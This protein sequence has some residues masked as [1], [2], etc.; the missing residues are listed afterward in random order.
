MAEGGRA[1]IPIKY[2]LDSAAE[3]EYI[4]KALPCIKNA[5]DY[6]YK[7][8]NLLAKTGKK[9]PVAKKI[10]NEAKRFQKD[11]PRCWCLCG[12]LVMSYYNM[13]EIRKYLYDDILSDLNLIYANVIK[14]GT[15]TKIKSYH[16]LLIR[17]SKNYSNTNINVIVSNR[18]NYDDIYEDF[19]EFNTFYDKWSEKKINYWIM[20]KTELK[21]CPYCNILYTYNRGKNVTAQLDHFFPKSEYPIFALCFY[22][23]IPSCPACNK[24]KRDDNED[25]ASPYKDGVFKDLRITWDCK[26]G[27]GHDKYS[28]KDSLTALE[29]MIEIR[30]ETSKND[31]RNNLEIMKLKEAYQ[32]HRDQACEIIKKAKIYTNPEAQ[33]LICN[34]STSEGITP[35][36]VERCYLGNYLDENNLKQRPL[37]KMMRDFYQEI[38]LITKK[39]K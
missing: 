38:Q 35:E 16:D 26:K 20:E 29:E 18:I 30:I 5:S 19:K 39:T 7:L 28:E 8:E 3:K 9:L 1:M 4:K 36:E 14:H 37:S 11:Y 2:R 15:I 32:Q 22:N 21:V 27:D 10:L 25:M 33:K 17:R 24:I 31:E 13:A 23:L 12:W 34:I 6:S